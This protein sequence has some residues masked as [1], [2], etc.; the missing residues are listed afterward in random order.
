[1]VSDAERYIKEGMRIAQ[2]LNRL[3][4]KV[5]TDCDDDGCMVLCGVMRDCAYKIRRHS[6]KTLGW[7]QTRDFWK[8]GTST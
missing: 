1:M 8:Q 5:Q 6:E 3:A 2:E 4:E 7:R